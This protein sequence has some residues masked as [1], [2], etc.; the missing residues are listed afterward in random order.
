M[1]AI[2]WTKYGPP[3]VLQLQEVEKPTP[4]N[5]EVLIRIYAATVTTGDCEIRRFKIPILLWIP[6]RIIFGITKPR[7]KMSNPN[8]ILF[9]AGASAGL[10]NIFPR[11]P[12]LGSQLF[13]QLQNYFTESWGSLP[14][15]ISNQFQEHFELGME[16]IWE[17]HSTV[18]PVLMR[19]MALFFLEFKTYNFTINLYH[20][21]I[22]RITN[23]S[24]S[25]YIFSSLNYELL[26]E[27]AAN[28]NGKQIS[29]FSENSTDNNLAVWKLHGSANFLPRNIQATGGVQFT[30]GVNFEGGIKYANPDEA[31]RFCNSDT[32]LYPSMCLFMNSKPTQISYDFIRNQQSR[33]KNLVLNAKKILIIG[34]R[35]FLNDNHIWEALTQT[36]ASV[37]F[38]GSEEHYNNWINEGRN[39]NNSIHIGNRWN[40]VF[41]ES[42]N[43]SS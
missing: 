11:P 1:K 6:V 23:N 12:P 20:T 39:E 13:S 9:G 27:F 2:V 26:L 33:W 31:M 3:D 40:Q 24:D 22:E 10:D 37:G 30:R 4:K 8:V 43:F 41:D 7:N 29:Y 17:H 42:I 25:N 14:E 15:T 16:E 21:F 34:V 32:A 18:V 38:I 35:P 28:S 5:N 36:E 19:D